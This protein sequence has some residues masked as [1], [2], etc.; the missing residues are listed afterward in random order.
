M[1]IS[2]EGYVL[3]NFLI[4]G[5]ILA[6]AAVRV[7]FIRPRRV[8]LGALSASLASAV[9]AG[10]AWGKSVWAGGLCLGVSLAAMLAGLRL[11]VCLRAAAWTALGV[12]L[13]AGAAVSAKLWNAMRAP[14]P[15]L[16]A[17]GVM[18]GLACLLPRGGREAATEWAMRITTRMGSADV[19]AMIDTGNR[20]REPFS[21]LPVLIVSRR[22]LS[23]VIDRVC[24]DEETPL[25]P[26]FRVVRYRVL[27]GGGCMR[28]FRPEK[29]SVL[30]DGVWV[31]AEEMWVAIYPGVIPGGLDA[32][33]PPS[34][35][36]GD[37]AATQSGRRRGL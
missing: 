23:G 22:C 18:F 29:I 30:Q 36:T 7:R 24:M 5:G 32:L 27:G 28:C 21:D 31:E 20:L 8:L 1:E 17:S 6:A 37:G 11:R 3:S 25:A 12:L 26:G 9:A 16:L 34:I 13:T 19:T 14:F 33:A 4:A 15:A 2:M 10:C 35:G